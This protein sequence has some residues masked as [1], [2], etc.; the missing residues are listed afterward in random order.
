MLRVYKNFNDSKLMF[1]EKDL[2]IFSKEI[3]L[4]IQNKN[5]ILEKNFTYFEYKKIIQLLRLKNAD[6]IKFSNN[7]KPYIPNNKYFNFSHAG[8]ILCMAISKSPIGVDIQ[9]ISN[10]NDLIANRICNDKELESLKNSNRK[11]LDLTK[12]WTQKESI[13]K[14]QGESIGEILT[15]FKINTSKF[16]LKTRKFKEYVITTCES[17]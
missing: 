4:K 12:L 15:K 1:K 9:K 16:K 13:I 10:Y 17:K 8:N 7:G 3:K 11:D 2:N 14:C 6:E 5:S